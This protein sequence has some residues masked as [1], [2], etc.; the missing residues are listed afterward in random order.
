[1]EDRLWI[2]SPSLNFD[3][4]QALKWIYYM[5]FSRKHEEWNHYNIN[6]LKDG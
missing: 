4:R 6:G 3:Y 1:M 5:T 2:D